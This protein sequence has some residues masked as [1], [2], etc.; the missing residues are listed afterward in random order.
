VSDLIAY[1]IGWG[2]CLIRWYEAGIK[3]EQP[4]MPGEGFVKWDYLA[5]AKLFYQKYGYDASSQQLKVFQETVFQIVKIIEKEQKTGNLNR[6]GVSGLGVP[7][8]LGGNGLYPT[9][10]TPST[11]SIDFFKW[12]T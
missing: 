10:R 7:F 12:R 2:K 4:E 5:I 11:I 8:L 6:Q 9:F 3:E 1:Q